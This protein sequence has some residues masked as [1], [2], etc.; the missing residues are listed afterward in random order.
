MDRAVDFEPVTAADDKVVLAVVGDFR[1]VRT[2]EV[3]LHPVSDKLPGQLFALT[4]GDG[5]VAAF[6]LCPGDA[7]ADE[8]C[9][10][11]VGAGGLDVERENLCPFE[12]IDH[13][14]QRGPVLNAQIGL[15]LRCR[16][17][18]VREQNG[19]GFC[20]SAIRKEPR[21]LLRSAIRTAGPGS[22]AQLVELALQAAELQLGKEAL[23]LSPVV[24]GKAEGVGVKDYVEIAHDGH[25]PLVAADVLL[26]VAQVLLRLGTPNLIDVGIEAVERTVLLKVAD[27]RFFADA[28]RTRYI[29]RTVA[30][31]RLHLE[32]LLRREPAVAFGDFD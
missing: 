20:Q 18:R 16:A 13:F 22:F 30:H 25:Q 12:S 3:G 7:K 15:S 6:A 9:A 4:V 1:Q 23:H 2:A 29:V 27:G 14:F 19:G 8:T 5:K 21:L 17:G 26:G 11:R 32:E 24:P 28:G 31:Q 10:H